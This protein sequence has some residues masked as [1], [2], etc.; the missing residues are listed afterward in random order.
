MQK[1]LILFMLTVEDV[2]RLFNRR[3]ANEPRWEG[4]TKK[5]QYV[6]CQ[7][8]TDFIY[9]I[10][11]NLTDQEMLSQVLTQMEEEGLFPKK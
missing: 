5:Q 6:I 7:R 11:N 8:M 9:T 3:W 2:A 10:Y 4:L 1:E